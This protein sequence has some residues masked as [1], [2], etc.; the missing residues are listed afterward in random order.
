MTNIVLAECRNHAKYPMCLIAYMVHA[1]I[2]PLFS[3]TGILWIASFI[4]DGKVA[5]NVEAK[6]IYKHAVIIAMMSSLIFLP[7]ISELSD[8]VSP[9]IMLPASFIFRGIAGGCFRLIEDPKSWFTI[10]LFTMLVVMSSCQYLII[11]AWYNRHLVKE[12]RGNMSN[13]MEFVSVTG[14]VLFVITTGRAFD[15]YGPSSPFTILAGCD[16]FVAVLA[17]ALAVAG[18]LK[19]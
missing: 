15:V 17:V 10:F 11:K 1:P 8:R 12:V 9:L 5:D 7:L 2:I 4:N 18:V 19:N 13:I 14:L 16:I 6:K 3:L